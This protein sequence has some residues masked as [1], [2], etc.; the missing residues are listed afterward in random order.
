MTNISLYIDLIPTILAFSAILSVVVISVSVYKNRKCSHHHLWAAGIVFFATGMLLLVARGHIPEVY[1]VLAANQLMIAGYAAFAAGTNCYVERSVGL[2]FAIGA[3][4]AVAFSVAYAF[5][6][7]IET[8]VIVI[9]VLTIAECAVMVTGFLRARQHWIAAL[10][11]AVFAINALLAALRMM[12][13]LDLVQVPGGVEILHATV[14]NFGVAVTLGISLALVALSV[15]MLRRDPA[16]ALAVPAPL[17]APEGWQ[18]LKDRSALVAPGGNEIRLTGSEY[19]LLRELCGKGEP[20]MRVV[21]N[22]A[23]GRDAANPKDRGIDILISRLRRKC[24]DA[25]VELPVTSVRG[26]GYVFHGELR[27]DD[28]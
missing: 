18:L 19:L 25:G 16:V 13:T 26:M 2:P 23:V 27:P 12:A 20:V 21:L 28:S 3:A 17:H 15:P 4:A 24:A 14:L 5:G 9:S 7:T 6:A 10:A 8:R 11:A 22:A 1:S